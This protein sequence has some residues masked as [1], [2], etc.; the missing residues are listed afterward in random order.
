[1]Y[2]NNTAPVKEGEELDVKIE[3]IGDKGDGI[4][5]KEG[6]VLVV[7]GTQL[8]DQVRVK[9]TKGLRKVGFA[10]VV[11]KS[12]GKEDAEEGA[13]APEE[14][15]EE[16]AEA[17]EETPEDSED[18]GEETEE[19]E[20]ELSEL[21]AFPGRDYIRVIWIG[22]KENP[23][24]MK[25]QK[26]IENALES[27]GFKKELDF[28]PHLTLARVQTKMDFPDIK[29]ENK[30]FKVDRFILYQSILKPGGPEYIK[31]KEIRLWPAAHK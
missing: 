5:K 13:E 18:F 6:F 10:E 8:N 25:L 4:A 17:P 21:G 2:G 22:T 20:L 27:F 14:P 12:S 16:A 24:L 9:I 31:L 7:P 15:A 11:G 19:F 23:I 26:D 29:I 30:K 28:H 1:M 3:A